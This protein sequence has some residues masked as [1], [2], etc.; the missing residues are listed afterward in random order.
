MTNKQAEAHPNFFHYKP[1][2]GQV[3]DVV[4]LLC[5]VNWILIRPKRTLKAKRK[6]IFLYL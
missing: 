1:P 2:W 5:L 4:I 6:F 3:F